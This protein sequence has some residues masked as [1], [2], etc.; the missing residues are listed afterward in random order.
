LGGCAE[1]APVSSSLGPVSVRPASESVPPGPSDN[2]SASE[3]VLAG[4]P[5]EF[6]PSQVGTTWTYEIELVGGDPPLKYEET[7]WPIGADKSVMYA[8]RGIIYNR[9]ATTPDEQRRN[10]AL[11]ISVKRPAAKQGRLQYPLGVEL[12]I[13]HDELGVFSEAKQVF[14]AI[15]DSARFNANLVVTV[16]SDSPSAPSSGG[17]G[18]WGQGDGS[19]MR[20]LF[21]GDRP[22][23]GIGLKDSPDKLLFRG[24]RANVE[25]FDGNECLYFTRTVDAA[26][27]DRDD[28]PQRADG[29][30]R[31]SRAFREEM[32]FARGKGL[33]RLE[34]IVDDKPTMTWTLKQIL[35][36]GP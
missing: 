21:F 16:D 11:K 10:F 24:V 5:R 17:F 4:H 26:K 33:V 20:L 32:W 36:G 6:F 12:S 28:L 15:S 27:S 19:A 34:Q 18:R 31:L 1:Q 35:K 9:S 3:R 22:G 2:A 23:I 30:D 25:N 29:A 14:W 13:D 7:S 8:T